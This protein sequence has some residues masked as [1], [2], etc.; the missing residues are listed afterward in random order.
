MAYLTLATALTTRKAGLSECKE[1]F[2]YCVGITEYTPSL[3]MLI[4]LLPPRS[5]RGTESALPRSYL[6]ESALPTCPVLSSLEDITWHL[7]LRRAQRQSVPVLKD[8]QTC[9]VLSCHLSRTSHGISCSRNDNQCLPCPQSC[10]CLVATQRNSACPS[11]LLM[12]WSTATTTVP[13]NHN[14]AASY[15][16]PS[17]ST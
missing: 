17:S 5:I 6:H 11:V 3:T 8:E 2:S 14:G 9:P 1:P 15:H 10:S 12:S 4:S 13:V 16:T 7:L